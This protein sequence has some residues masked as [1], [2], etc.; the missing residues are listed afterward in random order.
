MLIFLILSKCQSSFTRGTIPFTTFYHYIFPLL[1]TIIT[2]GYTTSLKKPLCRY[3]EDHFFYYIHFPAKSC[4]Y[5]VEAAETLVLKYIQRMEHVNVSYN[6][7]QRY[8]WITVYRYYNGGKKWDILIIVIQ[9][10]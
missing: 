9:S 5:I 8:F 1:S 7:P 4:S 6:N 3:Q 2:A 10:G